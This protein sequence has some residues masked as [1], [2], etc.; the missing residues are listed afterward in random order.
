MQNVRELEDKIFFE[1]KNVLDNLAKVDT[2]EELLAKQDIFAEIADRLAFLRILDQNKDFFIQEANHEIFGEHAEN[3]SAYNAQ[4]SDPADEAPED[5]IIEEEVIFTNEINEIDDLEED[6]NMEDDELEAENSGDQIDNV[7]YNITETSATAENTESTG[8]NFTENEGQPEEQLTYD[9][10]V[11]EKEHELQELEE[12]RR[13]IVE[14]T[15]EET[16]VGTPE[17]IFHETRTPEP[18]IEKK[19]K[20]ANIKGLKAVQNLFDGDPLDNYEEEPADSESPETSGSLLKANI[21]TEYM[22]APKKKPEF[23]I[24]FND[25]IAFTK[26]L[27]NGDE[28]ALRATV[29]HLNTFENMEDAKQYL[30]ELYY[31]KDWSKVD[32]YAQRL[33]DLVESKFL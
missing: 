7:Y 3:F 19:F 30:S 24:D 1:L 33:W 16:P 23:K 4:N 17:T 14:I 9:Q 21:P 26:L 11:A 10:R 13:K 25:K 32:E 31:E 27:F 18:H 28:E 12:R 15:K 5:E 29:A 6:Q 20:L 2:K 8:G 22:E